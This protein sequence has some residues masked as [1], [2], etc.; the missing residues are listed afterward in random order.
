MSLIKPIFY[1]ALSY[2]VLSFE[3]SGRTLFDRIDSRVAPYTEGAQTFVIKKTKQTWDYLVSTSSKLIGKTIP[4]Q[5]DRITS[6]LSSPKRFFETKQV[7]GDGSPDLDQNKI[8]KISHETY[9][10]NE[11]KLLRKILEDAQ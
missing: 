8:E 7:E 10:E 9:T 4:E 1:F 5:R 11:R 2:F 6:G 3:I